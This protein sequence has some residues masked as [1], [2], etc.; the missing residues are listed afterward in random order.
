MRF[1]VTLSSNICST[2]RSDRADN[3]QTV[4]PKEAK[5]GL[6]TPCSQTSARVALSLPRTAKPL[7]VFPYK[8][9]AFTRAMTAGL[10]VQKVIC[11]FMGAGLALKR[12]SARQAYSAGRTGAPLHVRLTLPTVQRAPCTSADSARGCCQDS[13]STVRTARY[14]CQDSKVLLSG[15]CKL[16]LSPDN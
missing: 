1:A 14:Y 6:P 5:M 13:R 7:H 3:R 4:W 2:R 12:P 16:M 9:R 8:R 10:T 15:Q 11:T